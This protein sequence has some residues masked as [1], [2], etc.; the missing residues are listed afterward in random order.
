MRAGRVEKSGQTQ[1][2]G[3]VLFSRRQDQRR[4]SVSQAGRN[5]SHPRRGGLQ[6]TRI[7]MQTLK[8]PFDVRIQTRR[9]SA[10]RE[11]DWYGM[12]NSQL[13]YETDRSGKTTLFPKKQSRNNIFTLTG[14]STLS[15]V[16]GP[17]LPTPPRQPPET[18]YSTRDVWPDCACVRQATGWLRVSSVPRHSSLAD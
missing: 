14:A 5:R 7:S 2:F 8:Q 13:Y 18:P 3:R 10:G 4:L 12:Q 15:A 17:A 6:S 9:H 16:P 1:D 11:Y